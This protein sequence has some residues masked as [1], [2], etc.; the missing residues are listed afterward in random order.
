MGTLE[1]CRVSL[2][3]PPVFQVR[4]RESSEELL[5]LVDEVST[6]AMNGECRDSRRWF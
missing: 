2:L 3:L 4:E 5:A 6:P 1:V